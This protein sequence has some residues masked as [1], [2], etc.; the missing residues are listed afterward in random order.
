M[1]KIGIIGSTG[2][3][4]DLLADKYDFES[5][6]V[7]MKKF[8]YYHGYIDDAEIF[9]TSRNQ[10]L[11]AVPPHEVDYKLIMHGMKQLDVDVILG[12]AVSGSLTEDIPVGSYL[13]LDQFLDFTKKSPNTIY[14]S[15]AFA[16]VEFEEPYCPHTRRILIDACEKTGVQFLPYGC[17]VGV[18][19]P[20]YETSAEVKMFRMLGGDVV[21]MTNVVE[22]IFARELGM[23][24]AA[25]SLI[26]NLGAG[27][28]PQKVVIRQECY[29]AT[30]A[31][32]DSTISIIK[33]FIELYHSNKDCD[34]SEKNND[35]QISGQ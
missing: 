33:N 29:D 21:G 32:L 3:R 34:C 16:F 13:V 6:D 31:M 7:G 17:Y 14:D 15:E 19:G 22:T 4:I 8:K 2:I 11:G 18:D 25:L 1:K 30:M 12:T 9:L 23:C 28:S 10:Y 35:M 26:S 24:Y 20:R 5:I 27:I